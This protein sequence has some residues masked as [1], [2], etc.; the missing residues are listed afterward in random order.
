M[1]ILQ[2]KLLGWGGLALMVLVGAFLIVKTNQELNTA[3]TTNTVSF[4]GQGK[5]M[6]KPDIGLVDLSIVTEAPTSKAAQDENS[7]KS[8]AMTD[9]LKKQGIAEKD[10][11]TTGYN[12]Y[13]QY[14]YT[15][16]KSVLR[17]YQVN[18]TTQVKVRDLTKAD[19]I[20]TGVVSAG[21]NQVNQLQLTVDDPE[22]LRNEA[23]EKAIKDAKSKAQE[24][25]SQL[26]VRLGHIVNFM[27]DTN[28]NGGVV[29]LKSSDAYGRGGAVPQSAP[30]I[31]TGENEIIVNVTIT[32]QIR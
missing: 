22:K 6:A 5:V 14:D 1:D 7:R 32:Y 19:D 8:K 3:A 13:P 16:G 26:G 12:I 31:S 25:Q 20:L 9:F 24:L 2:K 4:S 15:S 11:K 23:R 27:E 29:Y 28:G 17:G 18:Q 30:E 21:V 10:I